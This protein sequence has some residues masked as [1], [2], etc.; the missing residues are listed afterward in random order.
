MAI[1]KVEHIGKNHNLLEKMNYIMRP[2]S[3]EGNLIFT[4]YLVTNNPYEEMM[5]VKQ[6]Y[7]SSNN[8]TFQ[9]RQYFEFVLSLN[10]NESNR[11]TD[12]D[13][14]LNEVMD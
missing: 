13:S 14:C 10:E 8:N 7:F 6:C 5:F 1:L 12:F 2:E 4:R 11:V 3:T 9:R